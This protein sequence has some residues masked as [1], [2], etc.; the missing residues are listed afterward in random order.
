MRVGLP[1]IA[2]GDA[3]G[4]EA[5]ERFRQ[6]R[7]LQCVFRDTHRVQGSGVLETRLSPSASTRL[8]LVPCVAVLWARGEE[9]TSLQSGFLGS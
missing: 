1:E 3:D 9:R 2:Q 4:R 5:E 6:P 8:M 7:L